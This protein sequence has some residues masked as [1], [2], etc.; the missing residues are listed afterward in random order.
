MMLHCVTSMRSPTC[1]ILLKTDRRRLLGQTFDPPRHEWCEKSLVTTVNAG[2]I[3]EFGQGNGMWERNSE[4]E[5]V[6]I[7]F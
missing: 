7:Y 1:E 3:R 2:D 5:R 4:D 6:S